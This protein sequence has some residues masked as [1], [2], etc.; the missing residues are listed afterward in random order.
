MRP[1]EDDE[2]KVEILYRSSVSE[3]R[4]DDGRHVYQ[5]ESVQSAGCFH[6]DPNTAGADGNGKAGDR[7]CD[8]KLCPD[9]TQE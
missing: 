5:P 3:S 1:N 9:Y 8:G 4:A 7:L 6:F 2:I